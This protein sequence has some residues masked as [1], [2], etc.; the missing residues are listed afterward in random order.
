MMNIPDNFILVSIDMHL[1]V[2]IIKL[3]S[4]HMHASVDIIVS[5]HL[6][7]IYAF[8]ALCLK[9][10]KDHTM[11]ICPYTGLTYEVIPEIMMELSISCPPLILSVL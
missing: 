1:S 7:T 3:I 5:F 6:Q 4:R 9:T 11:N 10:G 2:D 8:E